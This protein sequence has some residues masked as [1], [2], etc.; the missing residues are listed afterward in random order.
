[1]PGLLPMLL[2]S[3]GAAHDSGRASGPCGDGGASDGAAVEGDALVWQSRGPGST[4]V[5]IT[6]V[7]A[8]KDEVW[9]CTG[10]QGL[11]RYDPTDPAA[12]STLSPL[13]IPQGSSRYPRCQFLAVDDPAAPTRALIASHVDE[14]QPEPFVSLVTLAGKPEVVATRSSTRN[15][16]EACF[17][18]EQVVV[19]AHDEGIEVLARDTLALVD[20]VDLGENAHRV[21]AVGDRLLVGTVDGLLLVLDDVL[22]EVGRI[23]L[24]SAVQDIEDLGDG[25]AAVALGSGGVALVDVGG[26]TVLGSVGVEGSAT[27]LARL[28]DGALAVSTWTD[29]R[30]FDVHGDSPELRAVEGVL[31][32]GSDPRTLAVGAAGDLLF[33]G[34]WT[35]LHVYRWYADRV[36]PEITLDQRV[37]K[38]AA[39]GTDQVASLV[40]TDEG[41]RDLVIDLVTPPEGWTVDPSSLTLSPGEEARLTLT[42]AGST[43]IRS[44]DL[45]LCTNDPDEAE[46]SVGLQQGSNQVTVGDAAPDFLYPGLNTG[47]QHSLSDQRGNVVLLSYFAT[48]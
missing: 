40:V 35:G 31:D 45:V 48:F 24:G 32:A 18:G 39:D 33:A 25:R 11:V 34:E 16:E 22:A 26:L 28:D 10:V 46:V 7:L 42:A 43:E 9:M 4:F 5:E 38:V 3:C 23:D 27:R 15:T 21:H 14:I 37:V 12:L 29:V 30:V 44:G 2:L 41:Q 36:G 19:A 1:M 6:D 17:F 20:V 47:Q 13:D 8:V